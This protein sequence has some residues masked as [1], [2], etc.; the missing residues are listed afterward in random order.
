VIGSNKVQMGVQGGGFNALSYS[1]SW[2]P[3]PF[4]S[5]TYAMT[6]TGNTTV[7]A[8]ALTGTNTGTGI[9]LVVGQK[10]T[11]LLTQDGTGGRT[12]T[13][14]A[15][16]KLNGKSFSTTASATTGITFVWDGTSWQA[17]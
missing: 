13:L 5:E 4:L 12:V 3:D 10:L 16:F 2:T 9:Y 15:V 11:L 17:I 8:P 6:L 14:N 1:S 7:G